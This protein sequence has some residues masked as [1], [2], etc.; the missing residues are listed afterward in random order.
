MRDT[1]TATANMLNPIAGQVQQFDYVELEWESIPNATH[2]IVQVSRVNSFSFIEYS[3]LTT[4][5]SLIA[6]NLQSQKDYYWRVKAFN[7]GYTCAPISPN[8]TFS[9]DD[10]L[11]T[12]NL[13]TIEKF[14]IY[15]TILENGQQLNIE[16][17]SRERMDAQLALFNIS[18]QQLIN[19]SLLLS[20]GKNK[21]TINLPNLIGGTYIVQIRTSEGVINEKIIVY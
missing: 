17:D 20:V 3:A 11:R 13:Q 21:S 6:T 9:T 14:S 7:Q 8:E 15:P 16:I 5:T 10:I 1:I 18:G 2:Y 19:N 4:D 12:E